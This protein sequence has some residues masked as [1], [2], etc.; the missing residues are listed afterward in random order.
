MLFR[1]GLVIFTFILTACATVN[2]PAVQPYLGKTFRLQQP[3]YLCQHTNWRPWQITGTYIVR[4]GSQCPPGDIQQMP[5]FAQY[6]ANPRPWWAWQWHFDQAYRIL[7]V[8]PRDTQ[9]R[10]NE[11]MDDKGSQD[12][13]VT[14]V[15][16]KQAGTQAWVMQA[17]E[18]GLVTLP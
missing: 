7:D 3:A 1:I 2:P 10:L 9:V 14:I 11:V 6:Q 16:G 18:N 8:L 5:S 17:N 13:S 12:Y 15:S 4:E